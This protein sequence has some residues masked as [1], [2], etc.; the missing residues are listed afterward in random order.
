MTAEALIT[1]M[2]HGHAPPRRSHAPR[3][4]DLAL[5]QSDPPI[6]DLAAQLTAPGA[7]VDF[8]LLLTGPPGTGKTALAHHLARA[9]DRPLEVKRASDLMSKWVGETEQRIAQAFA[10]AADQGHVL[11]FDEVDSL[12][13]DRRTSQRRWEISQVNEFLAWMDGHPAP[14]IAATNHDGKLDPAAMRRFDFKLVLE[15]LDREQV[16]LAWRR[17][18][19]GRAPEALGDIPGLTPG[20]FAV[21]ARQLR[22]ENR[23]DGGEILKRLEVETRAR[24]NRPGRMGFHASV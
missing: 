6:A 10:D 23:P 3:K 18:F 4:L 15:P 22:F 16:A 19:G 21:V 13:L 9:L 24:P 2:R 14:F 20:D 8:S 1:V 11:L 17:F 5:Y 12:L 7:P